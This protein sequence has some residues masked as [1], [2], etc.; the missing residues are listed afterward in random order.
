MWISFNFQV[1]FNE[2]VF[3]YVEKHFSFSHLQTNHIFPFV[4]W[5]LFDTVSTTIVLTSKLNIIKAFKICINLS[6][7]WKNFGLKNISGEK[8]KT[9][10]PWHMKGRIK[11]WNYFHTRAAITTWIK[12]FGKHICM[13][14]YVES[15]FWASYVWD[16]N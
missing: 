5:K 11:W 6:W 15:S 16:L 2:T 1:S 12:T 13:P 7:S 9:Y 4:F 14:F 8:K 10:K 3:K